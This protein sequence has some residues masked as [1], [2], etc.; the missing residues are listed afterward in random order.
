MFP[1]AIEIVAAAKPR[2][3]LFENVQR[4]ATAKFEGYRRDLL[5][6]L[7]KLGYQTEWRVLQAADFGVPLLRPRFILVAL[8]PSDAEHFAWPVGVRGSQT[9]GATL[10]SLMAENGWHGAEAWSARANSLLPPQ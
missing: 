7:N 4:L 5:V 1:A 10:V 9:V 8:L 2:A 3:V 6:R